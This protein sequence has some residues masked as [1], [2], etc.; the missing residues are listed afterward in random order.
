[1]AKK[2]VKVEVK[3]SPR[4]I[5]MHLGKI[6][7]RIKK[8]Q[9]PLRQ[10]SVFLDQWVQLNFDYQ[11]QKL[12]GGDKWPPFKAGGRRLRRRVSGVK[13]NKNLTRGGRFELATFKR[14][15]RGARLLQDTGALMHSFK[16]YFGKRHAGIRSDLPY[17]KFHHF[18]VTS[19]NLPARR[20]L[21]KVREVQKDINEIFEDHVKK[22]VGRT[23][24]F[25]RPQSMDFS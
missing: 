5:K 13:K 21:P 25:R 11:G 16:P 9:I 2:Q 22:S 6:E 18:G 15:E 10:A 3:P 24:K 1:M 8:L 23:Y 14:K 20:L 12:K 17:A 4:I 19:R 7:K